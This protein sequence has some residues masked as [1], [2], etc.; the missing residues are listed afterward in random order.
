MP[1]PKTSVWTLFA[2]APSK[3]HRCHPIERRF[4]SQYPAFYQSSPRTLPYLVLRRPPVE[5]S[6]TPPSRAAW[7][8]ISVRSIASSLSMANRVLVTAIGRAPN[9][10]DRLA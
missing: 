10:I 6:T 4:L 7:A 5:A 8:K 1:L 9:L 2:P 3:S